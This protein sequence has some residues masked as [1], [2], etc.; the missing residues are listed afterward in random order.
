MKFQAISWKFDIL[1]ITTQL[2]FKSNPFVQKYGASHD[3][4]AI[5]FC[6]YTKIEIWNIKL[7]WGSCIL[8]HGYIPWKCKFQSQNILHNYM[9]IIFFKNLHHFSLQTLLFWWTEYGHQNVT[10]ASKMMIFILLL[11]K[12]FHCVIAIL[13][14]LTHTCKAYFQ[15]LSILFL[16][17]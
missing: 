13:C 11:L 4:G 12:E 10:L 16:F 2:K 6:F 1:L 14:I 15:N 7:G 8:L 5:Y 9:Y 3:R 17:L